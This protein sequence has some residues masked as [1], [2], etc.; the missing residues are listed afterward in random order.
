MSRHLLAAIALSAALAGCGGSGPLGLP[1][2]TAVPGLP[3][4]LL[5]QVE[6]AG[7]ARPQSGLS[8][9]DIVY[10]YVAEGGVSRFTAI[11]F[12][13]PDGRVGPVRSARLVTVK[14]QHLYQGALIYAGAGTYVQQQ[15]QQQGM[16]GFDESSASG[17]LFRIDTRDPPHN[18]YTD[19]HH[20]ADLRQRANLPDV[21][22]QLWQRLTS[23]S[24]GTPARRFTVPVSIE[25]TPV[26]AWDAAAH[27]WTRTEPDTG[28]VNNQDTGQPLIAATV[29]V[30][31]VTVTPAPQ[32]VDVNG[33]IGVDHDLTSGGQAQVFT[34]GAMYPAT[35]SQPAGGPPQYA[36]AG[37]APAPIAPGLVWICLVPTGEA[38][39]L[40]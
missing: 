15:L 38:A 27:G 40:G 4:P 22:W 3:A 21:S 25:E 6:N 23:A 11:Y 9:A 18:L 36:L 10:E 8:G 24:G 13:G 34:G 16:P 37:G 32:V 39:T 7:A 33:N 29:I 35:W 5:V 17:D 19:A 1:A 26:F 20:A 12:H 28:P 31:Q 30:Q 14:L 2:P